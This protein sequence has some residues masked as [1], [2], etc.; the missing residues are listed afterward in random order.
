MQREATVEIKQVVDKDMSGSF[1]ICSG[2]SGSEGI[3]C[4]LQVKY[5][6]VNMIHGRAV[7]SFSFILLPFCA[8]LSHFKSLEFLVL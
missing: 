5:K 8:R 2:L 1:Q 4:A 6:H 7:T 3:F